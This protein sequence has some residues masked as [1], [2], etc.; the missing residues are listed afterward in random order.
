MFHQLK[1]RSFGRKTWDVEE[2][3][4]KAKNRRSDSKIENS[5]N[6][7]KQLGDRSKLLQQIG[8]EKDN[9]NNIF[10]GDKAWFSCELCRRRFKDN[11]KLVEHLNSKEHLS[12]LG[13]DRSDSTV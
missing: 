3:A 13:V 11:L 9:D 4:E 6:D 8:N 5:K 1:D 10:V 12:K 7:K 2:Y